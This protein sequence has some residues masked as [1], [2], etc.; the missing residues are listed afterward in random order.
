MK[1][2]IKLIV[3]AYFLCNDYTDE[4][5][6]LPKNMSIEQYWKTRG[7]VYDEIVNSAFD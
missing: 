5:L 4:K 1:K 7:I 3:K 2:L 6:M